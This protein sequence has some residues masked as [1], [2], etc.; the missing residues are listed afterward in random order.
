[1]RECGSDLAWR[2]VFAILCNVLRVSGPLVCNQ[3]KNT[4]AIRL[5]DGDSGTRGRDS[6]NVFH[7]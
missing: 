2:F 5:S 6:K 3:R 4:G 1:M 7:R